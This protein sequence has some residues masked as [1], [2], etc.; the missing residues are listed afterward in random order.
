MRRL[1]RHLLHATALAALF[2][3]TAA[4]AQEKPPAKKQVRAVAQSPEAALFAKYEGLDAT[5]TREL[6]A[7]VKA[8]PAR[9]KL[10][11]R[12]ADAL[13]APDVKAADIEA[14]LLKL[15]K[16]LE[17]AQISPLLDVVMRDHYD[18]HVA[19]RSEVASAADLGKELE[20]KDQ[21]LEAAVYGKATNTTK[22]TS[23]K[24]AYKKH[25]RARR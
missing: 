12:I 24:H 11:T 9:A 7:T 3:A 8:D 4:V 16:G 6:L 19:T 14:D 25:L 13:A 20:G 15:V 17:P 1:I 10:V 2:P 21:T 5:S 22:K 23:K 18:R